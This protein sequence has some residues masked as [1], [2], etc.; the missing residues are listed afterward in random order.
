MV[1]GVDKQSP[2]KG[3]SLTKQKNAF[4]NALP[5]NNYHITN[6]C[7]EIGITRGTFYKWK[8]KDKKFVAVLDKMRDAEI[9]IFE[10]AFRDLINERNPQVVMFALK[11]RGKHRGYVEKQEI[12]HFGLAGIKIIYE[13]PEKKNVINVTKKE[14]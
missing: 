11:T 2:Y 5:L 6:T 13:E 9:D 12:E 7:N 1:T 3:L 8:E 10:D 14:V 4:L